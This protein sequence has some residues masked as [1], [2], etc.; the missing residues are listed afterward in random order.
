[1]GKEMKKMIEDLTQKMKEDPEL[2]KYHY[3]ETLILDITEEVSKLMIKKKISKKEL[4]IKIGKS[5]NYVTRFL[6]GNTKMEIRT[7]VSI[8]FALDNEMKIKV[9]TK[10]KL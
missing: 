8:F 1:M 2:E 6:D 3:E 7:L 9:R 4:A 10:P 5:L